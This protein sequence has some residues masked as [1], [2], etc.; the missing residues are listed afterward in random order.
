MPRYVCIHGHFYQPP[1]ENPWLETV[2]IQES[3]SPWHDWNARI[4]AECYSRNSASRILNQQGDIIRICNNYAHMSFNIGPTLLTWLE[5]NDPLCYQGILDADKE[6]TKRFS[7]HGPAMAQVYNHIIMPLA[8][9]RDKETQVKWGIADF[10]KRFKRMP[11]GMWLAECAVDTETLEVLAENGILFTV[12]SPWQAQSVRTI[13]WGGWR[14]VS[15]AKIDTKCAYKCNLPSGRSIAIFFYDGVL[16][17]KIAF[18]GLLDDGGVFARELINAHTESGVPVLSHVATDGESYGHHHKHGDMALAYCLNALD[19]STEA[20]LTVYGEFLSFYPPES[21]VKIIENSSWSCAHGVERWRS[22]CSCGT[23]NNCSH[24]WRKPLRDAMNF[25]RDELAKLYESS[26]L[27]IDPWNARNRYIDVILDRRPENIDSFLK[28]NTDHK[29]THDERVKVLSL[30]EMQRNSLLMFT[31]CGWFFDEISRLEPVQIM[32]YAARAIELAKKL[33]DVDLEPEYLKILAQ[34]PSNI[35]ELQDGAKIYEL[36]AKQGRA[37]LKQMAAYFGINS[38]LSDYNSEF[39]EGCWD[40]SGNAERLGEGTAEF[41]AGT[42]HVKSHITEVEG[43]YIFAVKK[44]HPQKETSLISCGICK[45][46]SNSQVNPHELKALFDSPDREKL[47]FDKF[48]YDQFTLNNIPSNARHRVINELLQQDIDKLEQSIHGI[49]NDYDQLLE[50]LTL[51]GTK[52]PAIITTATEFTLT[53][54]IVK[55][56][57]SHAPDVDGI[58]RDFE[59][60]AFWQIN[61]DEEQIRFAFSDCINSILS[62]SCATGFDVETLEDLN[63]LIKLFSEK[64]DWHLSLYDAQNLYYELLK[65]Q[66]PIIK[67]QPEPLRNALYELGRSLRFSDEFLKYIKQ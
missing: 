31:S 15:G 64:F 47:L 14:D 33:F 28:D 57:E 5:E 67:T 41:S 13:G 29:L 63:G 50:Y 18:G 65:Q 22:N 48:G 42:V 1:R 34:A 27:L 44:N 54:E 59:L 26:D 39:S 25:L 53:A 8:S 24:E 4:S 17:Q 52:P 45:A 30:L 23:E 7:G 16:S 38:L 35:P 21:E 12:L 61:P 10:R 37:D 20:R 3:A 55:K 46:D 60:A 43:D 51:L 2:E 58:R 36:R 32:R 11:E 66:R 62:E 9:R 19:N 49:V 56:L 40:M 6:G